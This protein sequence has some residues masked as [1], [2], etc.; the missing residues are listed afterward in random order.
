MFAIWTFA[1][2][3]NRRV[4][5]K[6]LTHT[7]HDQT[8]LSKKY[9]KSHEPVNFEFEITENTALPKKMHGSISAG[10]LVVDWISTLSEF[11]YFWHFS[12]KRS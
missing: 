2:S 9:R 4:S 12:I 10:D 7:A 11:F 8:F 5:K 1:T 6:F 3:L